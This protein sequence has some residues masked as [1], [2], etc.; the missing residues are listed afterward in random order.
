M[1]R[2]KKKLDNDHIYDDCPFECPKAPKDQ[3]FSFERHSLCDACPRK[4]LRAKFIQKTERAVELKLHELDHK[5]SFKDLESHLVITMAL[6]PEEEQPM[7]KRISVRSS[8][9]VQIVR[10][11]RARSRRLEMKED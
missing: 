9:F 5:Y 8:R 1:W 11:E 3:K 2:L 10:E 4:K 7:D 6:V